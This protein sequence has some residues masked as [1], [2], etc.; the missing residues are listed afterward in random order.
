MTDDTTK[1]NEKK[2]DDLRQAL[3]SCKKEKDEYLDGWKR[4]KA[5]LS[6]YKKD[7]QKRL[8]ELIKFGYEEIMREL[9]R[10]LDSFELA[11][12][13]WQKPGDERAEKG[14]CLIKA[15]LEDVLKKYGLEPITA[16]PG[17]QFDPN[18]HEALLT[19][20][21]DKPHGTILEEIEKGYRLNGRVIRP[22]RVKVAK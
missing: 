20:A 3:E 16:D 2:P 17:S 13:S 9:V 15:Q 11:L 4:A 19:E 7:E 22:A 14:I 10:V 8:E 5:D 6:N 21:S 12:A 1:E 18:K